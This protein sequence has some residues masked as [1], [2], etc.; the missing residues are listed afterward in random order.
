M[1]D[2]KGQRVTI[3]AGS[4][5]VSYPSSFERAVMSSDKTGFDVKEVVEVA[6]CLSVRVATD[7]RMSDYTWLGVGGPA[8]VVFPKTAEQAAALV[9]ALS[10][11]GIPFRVIGHGSNLIVTDAPLKFVVISLNDFGRTATFHGHELEVSANYYM[12]RLVRVTMEKRLA[13]LEELGGIPGDVG[14]MVRMNAGA[15]NSEMK[16]VIKSVL[17]ANPRQGL[18]ELT[19]KDLDFSYRHS[20]IAQ[21]EIVLQARLVLHEDDPKEI[22]RRVRFDRKQRKA[23]QPL[24]EK[25]AGCIFKN[26]TDRS[27]DVLSAGKIIEDLGLKGSHV[28]GA[29]VSEKHGNFIVNR[30]QATSS[31]VLALIEIIK[32]K[33]MKEMGL[34]LE[35]EVELWM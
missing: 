29:F 20:S 17:A 7:E 14:G 3:A 11:R 15:Y 27:G 32:T 18:R 24:N 8:V 1:K 9:Q 23:S 19:A 6:R 10:A 25:S 26:P 28:G 16:M 33:V 12:A 35:E 13:G 30:A 31:D 34:V 2:E 4:W 5:K 21:D 22:A